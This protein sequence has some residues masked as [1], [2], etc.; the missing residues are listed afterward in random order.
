ML[1]SKL[2]AFDLASLDSHVVNIANIALGNYHTAAIEIPVIFKEYSIPFVHIIAWG[3]TLIKGVSPP[4][5]ATT[6][7][8]WLRY[9]FPLVDA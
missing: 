6:A 3:E 4:A 9:W 5:A 2:T 1:F 8:P 7:T